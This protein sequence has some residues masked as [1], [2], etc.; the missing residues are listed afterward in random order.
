MPTI[1]YNLMTQIKP[2]KIDHIKVVLTYFDTNFLIYFLY[3]Y[4][5]TLILIKIIPLMTSLIV[6]VIFINVLDLFLKI[7]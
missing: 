2:F 6:S 5:L 1:N 3:I 4:F 7:V